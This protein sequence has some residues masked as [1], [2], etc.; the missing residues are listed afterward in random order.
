MFPYSSKH[1]LSNCAWRYQER[2]GNVS[3]AFSRGCSLADTHNIFS[4]KLGAMMLFPM[5]NM[6][7]LE[8]IG[9]VVYLRTKIKM[10]R[11]D[12]CSCTAARATVQNMH[13]RRDRAYMQR[14]RYTIG[15]ELTLSSLRDSA[16]ALPIQRALPYPAC[17]KGQFFW[18]KC[19]QPL[20]Q[21][22]LRFT[23]YIYAL[24]R[25]MV[26]I[27]IFYLRWWNRKTYATDTADTLNRHGSP[28]RYRI[29]R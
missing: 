10:A 20:M 28:P 7:S 4:N 24:H 9:I 1:N 22:A 19:I 2:A 18:E 11:I 25:A 15:S 12:A 8:S 5:R 13:T 16:I 23:R 6:P 14:I 26:P 29:P 21:S 17:I 27:S 3:V